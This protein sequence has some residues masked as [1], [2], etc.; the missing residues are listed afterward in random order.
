MGKGWAYYAGKLFSKIICLLPY[1]L[2]IAGGRRLGI[3]YYRV[4]ERV[5]ER[6]KSQM[7]RG[8][9]LSA[10]EA[11]PIL[12]RMFDNIV[13]NT[14]EFFY[15][16]NISAKNIDQFVTFE[17]LHHLDRALQNGRGAIIL[18]AHFGN[19]ELCALSLSMLGYPV[20]GIA[21]AQPNKGFTQLLVE[22][23]TRFGGELYYKGASLRQVI[24][25]LKD[26]KFVYI[27]SDQDGGK[28]GIFIDFL[29]K[30]ASTPAGPA[31][32]A[33]KCSSPVIPVFIRREG[34]RHVVVIDAPLDLQETA[35][36]ADDI[37]H[38]LVI[39]TNRVEEQIRRYPDEWL[40]FQKRWN[41][42]VEV[43]KAREAQ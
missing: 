21:K 29:N 14:L 19:W 32:F 17:G 34:D 2:L 36:T 11:E 3:V 30:P 10:A 43:D 23:R 13:L 16:P 5:R 4:A 12:K 22:Y 18:T 27:V 8:L 33:R 40:W 38:N 24:K 28:D 41:T 26:N 37:R 31:A 15:L 7:M 20:M 9:G 42:P 25:A 6:A 39:I 1:R 35:N